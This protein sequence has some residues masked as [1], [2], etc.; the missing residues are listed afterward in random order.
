MDKI[1]VKDIKK[2]LPVGIKIKVTKK[3]LLSIP[4]LM[5]EKVKAFY[6]KTKEK[7]K[8]YVSEEEKKTALKSELNK[9]DEKR[10]ELSKIKK[11][12]KKQENFSADTKKYY[13]E[14]IEE[15]IERIKNKRKKRKKK[16]LGV[17]LI[18]KLYIS[19]Y[20]NNQKEKVNK[21]KAKRELEKALREQ[22]KIEQE[23]QELIER[24]SEIN[25]EK[26]KIS[27]QID[28]SIKV[29]PKLEEYYKSLSSE[30]KTKE[31]EPE[32]KIIPITSVRKASEEEKAKIKKSQNF[33]KALAA[34]AVA[35]GLVTGAL[36]GGNAPN[37]TQVPSAETVSVENGVAQETS[38]VSLS[39]YV[40]LENGSKI[41]DS[42]T[43][44]G[45][46]GEIGSNG[47]DDSTVFKI[48]A[49][50]YVDQNNH[51]TLFNLVGKNDES[52]KKIQSAHDEYLRNN[53]NAVINAFHITPYSD[54]E[55]N[56]S[57]NELGGWTNVSFSKISKAEIN[58]TQ[59]QNLGG[60]AI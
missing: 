29:N 9:F 57:D 46:S 8:N 37:V 15:E 20:I 1:T 24:L 36:V 51:V 38:N 47:Y 58:K 49:V 6:H 28:D 59:Q 30:E 56:V 13:L 19:K 18:G 31:K 11:Q 26:E 43:F 45:K 48:N 60:I 21:R 53:P 4:K 41:F 42:P 10:K 40:N 22:L 25:A 17:F 23:E 33:K 32:K 44:D 35:A 50:A 5:Y 52:K 3:R 54:T 14:A 55:T 7:F 2:A 34:I 39:D 27:S 16:G 12:V